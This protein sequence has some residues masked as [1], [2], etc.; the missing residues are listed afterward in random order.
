MQFYL[1]KC[2]VS[3][4]P[5]EINENNSKILLISFKDPPKGSGTPEGEALTYSFIKGLVKVLVTQVVSDSLQPHGLY[6][7]QVPL[8]ME[9]SKQECWSGLPFPSPGDLPNTGI[10]SRSPTL[11]AESLPSE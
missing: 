7:L 9:F 10:N 8:S 4:G 5:F 2:A 3:I 11:Q 6:S 1:E